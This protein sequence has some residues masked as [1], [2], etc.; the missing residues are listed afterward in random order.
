DQGYKAYARGDYETALRRADAALKLRPDVV[1]LYQLRVYALQKLNRLEEA[2][3]AAEEAIA[4]G[5]SSPELQAAL[6]NLR[7][8]PPGVA[9]V[10]T[11]AEY[12]KAFP[13]ATLAYEQLADGKFADAASNAEIAVR[14][15]PSQGP[16]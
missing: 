8:V 11:T 7:P 4:S 14:T 12:R 13:I 1:R 5:H 6:L 9:G 2:E 3:R 16:W 15:D 10:P